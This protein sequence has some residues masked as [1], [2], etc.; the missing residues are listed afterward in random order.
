MR[1]RRPLPLSMPE[2]LLRRAAIARGVLGSAR[3]RLLHGPRHPSWSL[4]FELT[5]GLLRALLEVDHHGAAL[6]Q[7]RRPGLVPPHLWRKI[8]L[9]HVRLDGVPAD[10]H[11]PLV[12]APG[13]PTLL[14]MH[15]GGYVTCSPS[16]H[17]H[18]IATLADLIPA[19]VV[20]PAYRL[21]PEHRFPAAL[22]DVCTSY[23]ALL[24]Q[25]VDASRL[26]LGGDSA[27]GGLA[28]AAQLRMRDEGRPLARALVL[29]SPWTDL[30]LTLEELLPYAEH[31]FLNPKMLLDTAAKYAGG[32][33]LDHP[34]ISPVHADL[35]GLPPMLVTTGAWELFY[36]QN[37]Q[38]VA[39]ARAAG[40]S[41]QHQIEPAMLHAY[42]AFSAL[43]P[44]GRAALRGIARF[45]RS[46]PAAAR[47]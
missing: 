32:E 28:I 4:P 29:M 17:R 41:V 31:D 13:D 8:R 43:V 34:L 27:G 1:A 40:V 9:T 11:T 37:C 47:A 18:L 42:P 2:S 23:A 39:R 7:R 35:H 10:V 5:M 12:Y 36:E 38:F 14:Y 16:S 15:G 19:R 25:G 6:A 22:D 3:R 24:A 45:V 20:A 21:A 30:S 46:F 44:Q 33:R 26:F